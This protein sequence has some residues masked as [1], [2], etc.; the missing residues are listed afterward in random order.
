M[1][2][3]NAQGAEQKTVTTNEE[4]ELV[5]LNMIISQT[6]VENARL[7]KELEVF[8][9]TSP[10]VG[11][12]WFGMGAYYIRMNHAMEG[13]AMLVLKGYNDKGFL[14]YSTWKQIWKNELVKKGMIVRD[15][16]V[17]EEIGMSSHAVAEPD[18]FKGE[19]SFT[20]KEVQD[21]LTGSA[22]NFKKVINNV[23][24]H[25]LI[26]H[27][28]IQ[29]KELGITDVTKKL[30]MDHRQKYLVSKY[31]W[32]N[33]VHDFDIQLACEAR[34]IPGYKDMSK[35]EIVEILVKMDIETD[36]DE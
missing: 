18:S 9:S 10:I 28:R 27:F 33:L 34:Q 24:S 23:T 21:L 29:Y 19:N 30:A 4:S 25:Q 7:R 31:N 35:E 36:T 6:L 17:L 8:K 26:D 13:Q 15:D 11:V 12:R 1:V 32:S 22:G 3:A 14:D 16:S 2:K 5:K 20:L